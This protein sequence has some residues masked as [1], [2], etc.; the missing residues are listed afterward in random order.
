MESKKITSVVAPTYLSSVYKEQLL[1]IFSQYV[2]EES[3]VL[4]TWKW[5]GICPVKMDEHW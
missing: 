2:K 1:G 4:G 3:I 5:L